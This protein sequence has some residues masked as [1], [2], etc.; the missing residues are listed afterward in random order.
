MHCCNLLRKYSRLFLGLIKCIS[1]KYKFPIFVLFTSDPCLSIDPVVTTK[2]FLKRITY[3]QV[4]RPSKN[5]VKNY[6]PIKTRLCTFQSLLSY[7]FF[8]R[9][10]ILI[11]FNIQFSVFIKLY[12]LSKNKN[13][14]KPIMKSWGDR[15]IDVK[16]HFSSKNTFSENSIYPTFV[17]LQT[18]FK[19]HSS[20]DLLI[21]DWYVLNLQL[22]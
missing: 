22:R 15:L 2:R 4:T 5:Q 18:N 10:K 19:K 12:F 1:K 17:S 6:F 11:R 8:Q 21:T 3:M 9:T 13:S 20:V 7:I 14:N 16:L